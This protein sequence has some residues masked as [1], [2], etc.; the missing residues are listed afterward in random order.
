M[1]TMIQACFVL[2]MPIL[3]WSSGDDDRRDVVR[4]EEIQKTLHFTEAGRRKFVLDNFSGSVRVTGTGGNEVVVTAHKTIRAESERKIDQAK[5]EVT[6]AI[7]EEPDRIVLY[8]DA[9]WRDKDGGSNYRGFDYYGYEVEY[10]FD[11]KVPSKTDFFV[12]TINGKEI[13]VEAMEGEFKVENVNGKIVMTN[14]AGSGNVSTVNG[15]IKATFTKNPDGEVSFRTVNGNLDIGFPKNLAA[16]L[17][18]KTFNGEVYSDYP[19]TSLPSSV[20]PVVKESN[21]RRIYRKSDS[22]SV[23][24]GKGGPELS[25]DTLN[26]NIYI[27]NNE[28]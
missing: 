4:T 27:T 25:F 1:N 12:R 28:Q 26:G 19:V 10:E 7:Q 22:F 8:V 18:L 21:R 20:R 17:K 2:I 23:R 16:D 11:V 14:V 13:S 15:G 6:L 3:F 5:Q 9:P 24:V